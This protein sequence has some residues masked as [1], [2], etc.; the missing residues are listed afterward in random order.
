MA[1]LYLLNY[2][3]YYNRKVK[4]E[5][6]LSG[7]SQY[8]IHQQTK[9]NFIPGDGVDTIQLLNYRGDIYNAN[10]LIVEASDGDNIEP[11]TR[12]FVL[13]TVKTSD[14]QYLLKLRL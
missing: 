1:N 11:F 3:N 13:D 9:V 8:I 14:S 7:Y 12:W 6:D 2:N 4:R 10:Y 5:N